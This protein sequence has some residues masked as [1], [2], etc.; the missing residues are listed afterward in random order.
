VAA[1][2]STARQPGLESRYAIAFT[3]W[4]AC[5]SAGRHERA[6]QAVRV[7]GDDLLTSVAHAATAG[8]VL[9]F[10]DT[11]SAGV[12]HVSAACAPAAL[13]IAA[14]LDLSVQTMLDAYAAGFEAMAA[15]AA[16]SHP[17]LYDSGWHP[18]AVCGPIG[19]AV[20]AARLLDLPPAQLRNALALA[21]LRAGGTRGAFGSDGKA[22]QVGQAAAAGVQAALLARAGAT[23]DRRAIDGPLGFTAVVGAVWPLD[24]PALP[25]GDPAPPSG[26]PAL[27]LGDGRPTPGSQTAAIEG[28]WIKLHPT[29]LGTHAP[30]EAATEARR[31]GYRIGDEPI[32][33]RVHPLARQ[34]AH[35]DDVTDGLSAKF[36]IPYCVARTLLSGPPG[37]RD[38]AAVD[39]AA[40][41]RAAGVAVVVDDRL[42]AFGAVLTAGGMELAHVPCPRGAPERPVSLSE[43][44]D[45]V[46][47]L[48]G[49]L[50]GI[51]ADRTAPAGVVLA[52]AG[53]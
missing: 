9:D 49:D 16:A 8:H 31:S 3:D 37:V 6:A 1:G 25:L 32:E 5:A 19:A 22:I 11:F 36:S 38:F 45:K 4:L 40:G 28:N 53:L 2:T 15:V 50:T 51:L 33:V 14:R 43:L 26:D 13:L 48:A 47:N 46:S 39:D 24:D 17:A 21:V 52:A 34:A 44:E 27:P 7:C 10:D 20:S 12:A 35:L 29:C 30:I 18:T 23:V 42:P 41:E